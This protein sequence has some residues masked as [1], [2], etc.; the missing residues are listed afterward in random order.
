MSGVG[1]LMQDFQFGE[2]QRQIHDFL[3]GE[4]CDWYIEV[5]KIRLRAD[6]DALSPIPV[7]VH[8]LETS[9][10]LLHPYMPF[11]TEELWQNIKK[12][13]PRDW[14]TADSIMV[15]AYPE[16]D[17]A[18]I[19][20]ESERVMGAIIEIIRS[21]RNVRA[22]HKVETTR[23]IEAQIYAGELK[24]A[25]T[26]Y[27]QTIQN[28]AKVKQV[29]F[30]SQRYSGQPNENILVLELKET[31]VVIT[32]GSTIDLQA[33]QQRL[34][35]EIEQIQAEVARL[36]A[37]LKDETFVTKAP[38]A[39]VNRERAKLAAKRDK[40]EKIRQSLPR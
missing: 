11:V 4:L 8:V 30:L 29:D 36:E 1:R 35:K 3:W 19:D 10:R 39:I 14:Q 33:E 17:E 9:L 37:R 28:L 32:M 40:L 13:L 27:S 6:S 20:P 22:E 16:A 34:N 5:A 24:S 23:Q 38:A 31:Q 7:L 25:I 26:P 18:T 21:I 12:K 15:A 2:A